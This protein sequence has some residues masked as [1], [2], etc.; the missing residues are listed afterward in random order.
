M[1]TFLGKATEW[2][3]EQIP[4]LCLFSQM[5]FDSIAGFQIG[6]ESDILDSTS[7][8]VSAR[9]IVLHICERR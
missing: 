7:C 1:V 8:T 6:T 2:T 3:P 4:P 5:S 9:K